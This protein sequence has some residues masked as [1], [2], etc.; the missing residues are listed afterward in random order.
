MLE[1]AACSFFRALKPTRI[2]G[3]KY[4]SSPVSKGAHV[5]LGYPPETVQDTGDV[6]TSIR[7]RWHTS[8]HVAVAQLTRL[9]HEICYRSYIRLP[10]WYETDR[11]AVLARQHP[12][13]DVGAS[14][15]FRDPFVACVQVFS[16]TIAS[17]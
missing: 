4:K 12:L 13:D 8:Q 11:L 14:Y 1:A 16:N 5:L 10:N 17:D 7:H 2:T 3:T 15:T 6:L 9:S